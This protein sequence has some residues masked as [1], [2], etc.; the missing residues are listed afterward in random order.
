MSY[1]LLMRKTGWFL[2]VSMFAGFSAAQ[3]NETT[4]TSGQT[5]VKTSNEFN[6]TDKQNPYQPE[7]APDA[8]CNIWVGSPSLLWTNAANW[9]KGTV[10]TSSDCVVI[11]A[12]TYGPRVGNYTTAYAKELTVENGG[13]LQIYANATLTVTDQIINNGDPIDILVKNGGSLIQTNPNALNSGQILVHKVFTLSNLRKQYNFI[14]SPVIGQPIQTIL[15]GDPRVLYHSEE[16]NYFYDAG[17]GPYVAGKGYAIKEPS[18]MAIPGNAPVAEFTGEAFNGNLDYI[19]SYKTTQGEVAHGFNVV[20]NPYPSNLD[21]QKLYD[22]PANKN[23]IEENFLFWDN[24][25]NDTFVQEGS[26][27]EGNSYAVYNAISKTGSIANTPV[28]AEIRLPNG[29]VPVGTAF[30][31]RAKS[32]ADGKP[33][34]FENTFRTGAEGIGFFGKPSDATEKD[35][36]HLIMTT[37]DEIQTMTAVVYTDVAV[38]EYS[39]EDTD[40][41]GNGLEL[42][43]IEDE[44]QILI[45]GRSE[46]H[47]ADKVALGMRVWTAGTQIISLYSTEGRFA[48]GQKIYIKDKLLGIT[49]NLT[50][51]PYK[52][53]ARKGEINN[54][55]ELV[56]KPSFDVKDIS[57][58]GIEIKRQDSMVVINSPESDLSSVMIY[59]L[60]GRPIFENSEINSKEIKIPESVLGKQIVIISVINRLGQVAGKKF[61]INSLG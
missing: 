22:Y 39:G 7:Y 1:K 10:P 36:Y 58:E 23:Y 51:K 48:D 40:A 54:R 9:S 3:L 15:D 38:N 46:F 49:H 50:A 37:P 43:T 18:T 5:A 13:R 21:I 20:G 27:Y 16:M 28:G 31:I 25:G 41:F 2:F 26:Q 6:P 11:P 14:I 35:S 42:Y 61:I 34:H 32:N 33:L 29:I 60:Y 55:F 8:D 19:L 17:I 47:P 12:A 24:R 53:L 59:D 52:F 56:Y 4:T 45:N 30:M 44:H 57:I